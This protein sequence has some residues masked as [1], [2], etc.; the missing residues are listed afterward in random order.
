MA[1][2]NFHS[3]SDDLPDYLDPYAFGLEPRQNRQPR[4]ETRAERVAALADLR[5]RLPELKKP[6]IL[7]RPRDAATGEVDPVGSRFGGS[8]YAEEEE[9][10]PECLDCGRPLDFVC[11]LNLSAC[12]PEAIPGVDLITFFYCWH[13]FDWSSDDRDSWSVRLYEDPSHEKAVPLDRPEADPDVYVTRPCA[14]EPQRIDTLPG[15]DDLCEWFPEFEALNK[16]LNPEEPWAPYRRLVEQTVGDAF[17]QGTRTGG[18]PGRIQG[19]TLP[20]A[21]SGRPMHLL[22]QIDSEDKA[23]IM[24]GD[25]GFLYLFIDPD[26]HRCIELLVECM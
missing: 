12:A 16:V 3:A 21:E 26:D 11:Q 10:W 5:S 1:R 6:S 8:P 19:G 23:G 25:C 13:T 7:F 22:A 17:P 4:S 24:W 15:H 9:E 20:M 18:W 2:P 14:L